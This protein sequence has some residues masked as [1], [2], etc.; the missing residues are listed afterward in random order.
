MKTKF[1]IRTEFVVPKVFAAIGRSFDCCH[2]FV[3]KHE[4]SKLSPFGTWGMSLLS[5]ATSCAAKDM[6]CT[7]PCF[8]SNRWSCKSALQTA[9]VWVYVCVLVRHLWVRDCAPDCAWHIEA[10]L[11]RHWVP[12]AVVVIISIDIL[13]F[14]LVLFCNSLG[15]HAWNTSVERIMKHFPLDLPVTSEVQFEKPNVAQFRNEVSLTARQFESTFWLE[16]QIVRLVNQIEC[17]ICQTFSKLQR[18]AAWNVVKV[19][20]ADSCMPQTDRIVATNRCN[21]SSTKH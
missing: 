1:V 20:L 7:S 3:C 2:L 19:I 14:P 9:C 12:S 10:L 16:L 4:L 13:P 21:I 6:A 15:P 18:F 8:T 17:N 11:C 5:S